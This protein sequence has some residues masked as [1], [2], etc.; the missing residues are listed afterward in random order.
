MKWIVVARE[1]VDQRLRGRRLVLHDP[2][3][4]AVL[5]GGYMLRWGGDAAGETLSCE[6]AGQVEAC[7]LG[8]GLRVIYT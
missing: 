6:L 1:A 2:V 8:G 7:G 5:R 3:G 4:R